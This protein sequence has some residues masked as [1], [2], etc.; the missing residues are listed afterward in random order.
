VFINRTF[1]R[2]KGG[3]NILGSPDFEAGDIDT[4]GARRR[5]NLVRVHDS[6]GIGNIGH[7]RQ[8]P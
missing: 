4:D 8:P 5:L 1:E 7:D 2:C 3:G 6:G